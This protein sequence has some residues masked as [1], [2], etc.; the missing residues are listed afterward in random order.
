M[1]YEKYELIMIKIE[2]F[3]N[4][5]NCIVNDFAAFKIKNKF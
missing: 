3:Y 1:F 5:K 2:L 4:L